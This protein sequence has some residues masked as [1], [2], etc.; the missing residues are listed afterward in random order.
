M[1]AFSSRVQIAVRL[2][3]EE[4]GVSCN[5]VSWLI[6]KTHPFRVAEHKAVVREDVRVMNRGVLS[7][8]TFGTH[9]KTT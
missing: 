8:V 4:L 6:L 5:P 7:F 3:P 1:Y 9:R 2:H